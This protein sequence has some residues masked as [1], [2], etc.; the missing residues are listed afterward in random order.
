MG[1]NVWAV[2]GGNT[3]SLPM[4]TLVGTAYQLLGMNAAATELQY[5]DAKFNNA[6]GQFYVPLG[7]VGA[8]SYSF[9]GFLDSGFY[10]FGGGAIGVAIGGT[11][12]GYINANSWNI[13]GHL[14]IYSSLIKE[15]FGVDI[16]AAATTD[17]GNA[18]G[19]TLIVNNAA[20]ATVITSLG[21]ATVPAGTEIET[22]FNITGGSVTF[23]HNVVS[24]DLLGAADII[25]VDRDIVRWRKTNDASA[26][27]RMVSFQRG[28]AS[29]PFTAK[30]DLL[31]GKQVGAVIQQSVKPVGADNTVLIADSAQNDGTRWGAIASPPVRQT[32]LTAALTA[33][34]LCNILSAGAALN[35]NVEANP[36][37]ALL[38][39]AG[40]YGAGGQVDSFSFL[41]AD[42]ANQGS[43]VASNI[44]YIYADYSS[45]TSVTW[46]DCLIPPQ[47]GYAFDRIEGALLNFEGADTSTIII[48]GLGNT[49]NAVGNAQI[50]TAQ[51]KFGSSSLLLDG[52]GDYVH[53]TNFTTLGNG[54]WEAS[55]WFRLNAAPGVGA[56]AMLFSATSASFNNVVLSLFNNGGTIKLEWYLSSNGTSADIVSGVVGT[57]TVWTLNQWNKM[58]L[59][60]DA[61]AGTYRVYLSLN[62]AAETQDLTL[63]SSSRIAGITRLVVGEDLINPGRAFNGWIDAVRFMRAATVT[64]TETPVAA[65][66]SVTDHLIHF[67]S[68]PEM[69]MYEVTAE[70]VTAAVNPTM[71]ARTRLFVGECDTS[72]GA[73]TAVR[74][75]ALRGKY[76]QSTIAIIPGTPVVINHNIG[77]DLII[78]RFEGTRY[79]VQGTAWPSTESGKW[80]PLW[81]AYYYNGATNESR[82]SGYS[83]GRNSANYYP[84]N[85]AATWG[86]GD[87]ANSVDITHFRAFMERAF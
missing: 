13:E 51:F 70:S 81:G 67:F 28:L 49:W 31:V 3:F 1:A 46:S 5:K 83:I 87:D 19:N 14:Q 43:F 63:S 21:G 27:W 60:F 86:I 35:F 44:N 41:S 16:T 4:E 57:N 82:G 61:L 64:G 59:V 56:R 52:T 68:I 2:V 34:G 29:T 6:T 17:L 38:T 11:R 9:A 48:D 32:V 22:I 30:G 40:G 77:T 72:V 71:V 53:S 24:L 33:A 25:L 62:G 66:P 12:L 36:T 47:Q 74:N 76:F 69:K 58:R 15:D 18:T 50:D 23:T 75:Y 54:S 8:P 65:A 73:V 84:G 85:A 78:S 45:P 55:L 10:S 42:Q 80:M 20:G 26:Y 79:A 37:P 39:F 7:A